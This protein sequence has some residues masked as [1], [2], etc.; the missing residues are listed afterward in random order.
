MGGEEE[1]AGRRREDEAVGEE[2][3]RLAADW[4]RRKGW[5]K[6]SDGW[7]AEEK[8]CE[9]GAESTLTERVD[10]REKGPSDTP[11]EST[12]PPHWSPKVTF[13]MRNQKKGEEEVKKDN[14]RHFHANFDG[15]LV[16][17]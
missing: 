11:R 2:T 10:L 8:H 15:Q 4:Q 6:V 7:S 5:K 3:D 1:A 16:L 9:A 13:Q 14:P 12:P 17:F